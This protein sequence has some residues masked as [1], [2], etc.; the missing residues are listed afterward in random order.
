MGE[1]S[2]SWRAL[3][4]LTKEENLQYVEYDPTWTWNTTDDT[5]AG[6][7]HYELYDIAKD[8]YQMTNIYGQTSDAKRR[9]LHAAISKYYACRGDDS[10]PTTCH[11]ADRAETGSWVKQ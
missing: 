11:A 8:P 3:R 6:L 9:T 5:G 2:N 10:T 7:Q 4:I 1:H